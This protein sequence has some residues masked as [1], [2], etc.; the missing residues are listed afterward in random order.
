WTTQ[1]AR[2]PDWAPAQ[3]RP[4][5][6]E[7]TLAGLGRT[8]CGIA[9]VFVYAWT[10]PQRDPVNFEDWY[11][12]SPPDAGGS[13]DASAFATGLRSVSSPGPPNPLCSGPSP[14]AALHKAHTARP[15]RPKPR[16]HRRPPHRRP[17]HPS[18]RSARR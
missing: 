4:S 11:G 17:K 9:G 18:G 1:P 14:L 5:Y 8:D 13:P 10:T 6:I 12:I 3:A 7:R 15:H 2:A 16:R